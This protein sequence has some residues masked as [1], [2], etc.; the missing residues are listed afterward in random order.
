MN[1]PEYRNEPFGDFSSLERRE[2]MQRALQ[3]VGD[4]LGAHYPVIIHGERFHTSATILS[5]APAEPSRIVGY[6]SK[7]TAELATRAI[8]SA[9][10]AFAH[11][12][13]E[14]VE[15]R[16]R[17]LLRAAAIMR[18]RKEELAA[19]MVYEVSKS[20]A[21]ADADVAEAIDFCEYYARQALRLQGSVQPLTPW[22]GEVNSLH[23]IPLGA[24]V[25][26]PPWNFPLAIATNLVVAPLVAGNTVVLKPASTAPV[27]AA[28]LFEILEEAGLPPGVVN[29]LP[30][31]G[32]AVGDLLIDHPLTRFI[33][34]TGSKEVG[35]RINERASVRQP[36]Q[37]WIK[38]AVLEMGGKDGIV[39]DETADLDAAAAGIVA[40]AFGFQGQKCSACSRVI[41][42]ERVYD[43][44]LQRVVAL[45]QAIK[46]GNPVDP[47]NFMG[48]VI[49]QDAFEKIKSY[50]TIGHQEGRLVA[51]GEPLGQDLLAGGGYFIRPTIFADIAPDAR[52]A[53]EEIF[54]PVLAVIRARDFEDALAI[55]NNTEYGLTGALFSNDLSRIARAYEDFHVGNLYI[56]RKC[57]GALVGVQ[58]F[59]GFNMSGTD[60]KAGGPDYLTLFTQ[61]KVISERL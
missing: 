21:E 41:I 42:V 29:Y 10:A 8:E 28:K 43:A 16:A 2:A 38:R 35:L 19:W 18:R 5:R 9:H 6:V 3:S 34:F 40:A 36:G 1:L 59:G 45:T 46:L 50:I 12:R 49:D 33:G 15:R 23:Y 54:G 60:S 25:A 32:G 24:G 53:Q 11:W 52:L 17:L 14:S 30:G 55:A 13:R 48:A 56:N 47:A 37:L 44:L 20:W 39:V 31:S 27:I 51:G 7:A 58:P 26:I 61:A 57:T 22:P 4:Q